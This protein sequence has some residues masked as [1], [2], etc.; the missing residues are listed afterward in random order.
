MRL[1]HPLPVIPRVIRKAGG[2]GG[3]I[4][5]SPSLAQEA[6]VCRSGQSIDSQTMEDPA[7]KD[8]PQPGG[9]G[10]SRATV[11]KADHLAFEW[12]ALTQSKLFPRVITTIQASRRP[13]TNRIYN[14][15]WKTFCSWCSKGDIDPTSVTVGQILEFLQDGLDKGL[16][17]STI[18]RQVA[19]LASVLSC[20][21]LESLAHHPMVC[22]FIKGAINLKPPVV[23]RYPT[24]DLSKVLQAISLSS[25]KPL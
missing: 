2:E 13:S 12:E 5:H 7:R 8:I 9:S 1:P 18:H 6:V 3:S 22:S 17:P 16:F 10:S 4:T 20:G 15:T 24:W 25:F 23:C 11:V 14:S 19:A 21:D